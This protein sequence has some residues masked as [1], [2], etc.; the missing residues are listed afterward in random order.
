MSARQSGMTL[1]EVL[2]AVAILMVIGASLAQ[3]AWLLTRGVRSIDERHEIY[4][5][6]KVAMMKLRQ[7]LEMAFIVAAKSNNDS[8]Q[9]GLIGEDEGMEDSLSFTTLAGRRMYAG[10]AAA[11]QREVGYSLEELA[12]P[13]DRVRPRGAYPSTAKQLMRR[14]SFTLDKDFTKGGDSSVLVEGVVAMN[15]EYWDAEAREWV[16][17]WSTKDSRYTNKLPRA[18]RIELRFPHPNDPEDSTIDFRTTAL[19]GMTGAITL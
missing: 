13:E 10:V 17:S 1:L 2:V 14:E 18:V 16:G 5:Q 8:I 19:L 7:D 4:H 12:E 3:S 15:L 9:T 6:G 11:D